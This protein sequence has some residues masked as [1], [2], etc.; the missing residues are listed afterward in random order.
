MYMCVYIGMFIEYIW[1]DT[2]KIARGEGSLGK[3]TKQPRNGV[4]GRLT[5]HS[6]AFRTF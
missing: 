2:Q 5:F 6:I 1:K 3:G 4:R